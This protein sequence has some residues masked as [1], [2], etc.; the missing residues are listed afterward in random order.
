MSKLSDRIAEKIKEH[1][2]AILGEVENE[3]LARFSVFNGSDGILVEDVR[4]EII[5]A[6]DDYMNELAN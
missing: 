5:D 4:D 2:I 3:V 6:F 1:D